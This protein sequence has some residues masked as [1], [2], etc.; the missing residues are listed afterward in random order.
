MAVRLVVAVTDVDWFRHLS[1][2]TDLEE[3]NFWA[4]SPA[5]LSRLRSPG[6]LFL[7]K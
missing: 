5:Q 1:A 3:V 2:M 4:P 6:E 7:F